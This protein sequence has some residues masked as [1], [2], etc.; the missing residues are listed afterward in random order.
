MIPVL[1]RRKQR[2]RDE[3]ALITLTKGAEVK[4]GV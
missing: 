2:L 1:L 3:L 4:C